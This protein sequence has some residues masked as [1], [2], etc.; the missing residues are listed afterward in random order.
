MYTVYTSIY[1]YMYICIKSYVHIHI[2]R[3]IVATSIEP[4]PTHQ[5]PV[6]LVGSSTKRVPA[7]VEVDDFSKPASCSHKA[8]PIPSNA[9][10]DLRPLPTAELE[11]S[12]LEVQAGL[13][14]RHTPDGCRPRKTF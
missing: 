9:A 5:P 13:A 11:T 2:Y 8:G 10:S 14:V 3:H 1:I 6:S 7:P 12:V 4:F